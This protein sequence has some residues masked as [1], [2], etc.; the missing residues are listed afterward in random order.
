VNGVDHPVR[1][2]DTGGPGFHPVVCID[3][4]FIACRREVWA[5]ILF[6]ADRLKG[7]HFYDIDFSLR[8]ARKHRVIVTMGIDLLHI[9]QGGDYGNNW[10]EAAM[11]YHLTHADLLPAALEGLPLPRPLAKTELQIARIW[12]DRLKNER[13]SFRNKIR[14][15]VRQGLG[16]RILSLWYP[17]FRFLVFRPLGLYRVQHLIK[18]NL[19][20]N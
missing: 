7:F 6:D 10:V 3:G 19:P 16:Q 12:L 17:I 9:T 2:P 15:I 1:Q 18:R 8:A 14:W 13:I 20:S 5:D 4:V 11:H